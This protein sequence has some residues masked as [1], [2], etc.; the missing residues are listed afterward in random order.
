MEFQ[1]MHFF[2][3]QFLRILSL[4]FFLSSGRYDRTFILH[5]D[6]RMYVPVYSK[7]CLIYKSSDMLLR[8]QI[9]QFDL[10]FPFFLILVELTRYSTIVYEPVGLSLCI[11]SSI[12][13]HALSFSDNVLASSQLCGIG[14]H[15]VTKLYKIAGR[16]TQLGGKRREKQRYVILLRSDSL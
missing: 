10:F 1:P 9:S 2:V 8:T 12:S 16:H 15:S 6:V 11:V 4:A 7:S 13:Q 3:L 14:V 5:S